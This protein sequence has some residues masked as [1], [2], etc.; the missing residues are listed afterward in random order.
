MMNADL[1]MAREYSGVLPADSVERLRESTTRMGALIDDLLRL[2]RITRT[3]LELEHTDLTAIAT[4]IMTRLRNAEP[5]REVTVDIQPDM[6]A[7][8]DA[9]LLGVVLENLLS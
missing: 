8:A 4:K 2:S 6:A 3:E 9:G 1:D 5:H 7:Q